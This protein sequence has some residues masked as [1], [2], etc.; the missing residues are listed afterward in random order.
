M[1]RNVLARKPEPR[2]DELKRLADAQ[3]ARAQQANLVVATGVFC[4]AGLMS[5]VLADAKGASMFYH[6]AF[7]TYTKSHKSCALS[8][9][10]AMLP[11]KGAARAEVARAITGALAS[12]SAAA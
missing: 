3:I 2:I 11:E 9:P 8:V 4:T 12:I 10:E 7:G 1:K 5:R 6:G